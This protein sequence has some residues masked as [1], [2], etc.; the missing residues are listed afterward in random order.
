MPKYESEQSSICLFTLLVDFKI[1][2]QGFTLRSDSRNHQFL[3]AQSITMLKGFPERPLS[4]HELEVLAQSDAIG[5]VLP[6]TPNSLRV[7]EEGEPGIYDLLIT[8][9]DR[10]TAVAYEERGDGWIVVSKIDIDT[11]K[12][13]AVDDIVEYRDY[14]I[15]DKEKVY[16]FV[17][18]LYGTLD[19]Q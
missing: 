19:E 13:E 9:G 17:T 12:T 16:E 15:E 4:Y 6:A 18:E 3:S 11:P 1:S 10:V 8:I 2:S 14:E 5:F 7:D